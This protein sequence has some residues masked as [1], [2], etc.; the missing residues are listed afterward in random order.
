MDEKLNDKHT[1]KYE[2]LRILAEALYDHQDVRKRSKNRVRCLIRQKLLNLGFIAE[3]KI[4]DDEKSQ[5][6]KY[7]DKQLAKLMDEALKSGKLT[8]EDHEFITTSLTLAERETEIEKDYEKKLKPLVENEEIWIEWLK[9]VKGISTRNTTRLLKWYGY[10]ERFPTVS[11]LWAYS[12]LKVVEGKCVKREKGK[13]L[14]YNLKIKT[15][16][17]GILGDNLIKASAGYK[18]IY[19][20]DKERILLRGC[21]DNPKCV[22]K[23][24]HAHRMAIRKMVKI[25]LQH[26]WQKCRMIKG[27]E[28]SEPWIMGVK[29][30]NGGTHQTYI[31]PIYD[32]KPYAN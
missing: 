29:K 18:Q 1:L 28:V 23:P 15:D 10:C 17:V 6:D 12:G 3:E 25:F 27:L 14:G 30:D 16:M 22:G 31:G 21:C 8:V 2:V 5:G 9:Y 32:K 19:D 11:K 20:N 13:E 7:N 26:Y 4:E 24:G